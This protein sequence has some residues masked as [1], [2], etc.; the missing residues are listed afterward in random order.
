MWVRIEERI[1]RITP[2]KYIRTDQGR[3]TCL[4]ES[5]KHLNTRYFD[6]YIIGTTSKN[7]V[8]TRVLIFFDCFR[9]LFSGS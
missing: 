1:R 3:R 4:K 6:D 5:L 8:F 7:P 9:V 2:K